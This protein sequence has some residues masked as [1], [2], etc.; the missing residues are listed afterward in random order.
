MIASL[1]LAPPLAAAEVRE[2]ILTRA[3]WP[4]VANGHSVSALPAVR[5][6][7]RDFEESARVGVVV[8]H[9]GG[10]DGRRWAGEMRAWLVS[11]GVPSRWIELQIGAGGDDQLVLGVID[12]R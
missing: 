8:R 3:E 7:L 5:A 9:P 10:G 12:R 4:Q 6:V 1:A 2:Q 11:L